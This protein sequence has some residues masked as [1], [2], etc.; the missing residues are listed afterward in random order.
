M[1]PLHMI[2]HR[3]R[4]PTIRNEAVELLLRASRREGLWDSS[5]IGRIAATTSRLE[6]DEEMMRQWRVREVKTQFVSD[7]RARLVFITGDAET[8]NQRR[9]YREIDW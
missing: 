6:Q 9:Y 1:I 4:N 7:R 3:C 5:V 8:T 2:G